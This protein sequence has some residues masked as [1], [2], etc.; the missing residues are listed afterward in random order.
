MPCSRRSPGT[1]G[2]VLT[3]TGGP[4]GLGEVG[5]GAQRALDPGARDLEGVAAREWGRAR[6]ARSRRPGWRRSAPRG[7]RRPRGRRSP[8]VRPTSSRR[9]PAR[10][11]RRSTTGWRTAKRSSTI[12]ASSSPVMCVCR[13]S[14]SCWSPGRRPGGPDLRCAPGGGVSDQNKSVGWPPTP[15]QRH[16][17]PTERQTEKYSSG[18]HGRWDPDLVGPR[19]GARSAAR[20]R[21]AGPAA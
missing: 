2:R 4:D 10:G 19:P 13:R 11:P 20:R 3:V 18:R 7:P 16:Y 15:H 14:C 17:T 5:R 21:A 9:R 1:W 12:C 6:R 8:G